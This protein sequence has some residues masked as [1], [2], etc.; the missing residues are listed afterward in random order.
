MKKKNLILFFPS[1]D[2][3]NSAFDFLGEKMALREIQMI[4]EIPQEKVNIY[5]VRSRENFLEKNKFLPQFHLSWIKWEKYNQRTLIYA[6]LV[7]GFNMGEWV[8]HTYPSNI[9]EIT[10][11]KRIIETL[12]P[13]I[14]LSSIIC[15]NYH[16][17]TTFFQKVPTHVKVLKPSSWTMW[18]D[19]YIWSELPSED[20]INPIK[21][22][23]LLQEYHDTSWW[24]YGICKW[25]HDFRVVILWGEIIAKTL[26]EPPKDSYIS[27][28]HQWWLLHNITDF[29]LPRELQEVI[30]IIDSYCQRFKHR[31]Y[32][33]DMGVGKNGEIKVFE[34]NGAP[35]F[36]SEYAAREFWK[37]TTKN[38]LKVL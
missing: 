6:D 26:R 14:T 33:I 19:I 7:Y 17:I 24:F 1:Q 29:S 10:K 36:G 22:P 15:N 28:T 18:R 23:Y 25:L 31:Y 21:Y 34:L 3:V 11:D 16:E 2:E 32:S 8:T 27:N 38:I 35:G 37:Y 30:Q 4:E 9:K 12:F 13:S 20:S 5:M